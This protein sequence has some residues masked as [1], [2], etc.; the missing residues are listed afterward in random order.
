MLAKA[1]K[2]FDALPQRPGG[3][4]FEPKWDGFRGLVVNDG[5]TIEIAS[6]GSK[7][8]TRYF[9]ELVETFAEQVPPGCILDGELI[10]RR[11]RPGAERL[12]WP[13]LAQRIHPAQSRIRMLAEQTPAS[14][15]A[16]DMLAV[17]G[18]SLQDEP[19]EH[20]RAQLERVAEPFRAPVHLSRVTKDS[21]VAMRWFTDFEGAGLDGVIAKPAAEVYQPGKRAIFKLKHARTAD[22]V[23]L[24]YRV[25]KSG[26][27]IGSLLLGLYT[28]DGELAM[29][30]GA[31]SFTAKRRM[32]L[33][34][35]LRPL[36]VRDEND[37]PVRCAGDQNRF[38][39]GKDTSFM[40]LRPEVVAEVAYDQMEGH[41]FRHTVQLK[42]FRP[43]RDPRSCTYEQLR[44]PAAHD[45]DAVL[46][47][48]SG[49]GNG[50]AV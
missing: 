8:L 50:T 28:D 45:L 30:G 41:R 23:L 18:R 29:V 24:G 48:T 11:G 9:P 1:V 22:V 4:L 38:S 32:E 3:Y 42:R 6:R 16:F 2:S 46:T 25:H 33:L 43:D 7:P 15:V 5:A 34:E 39:S 37:E 31:A 21:A 19:F 13:T 14:F 44:M 12:D 36:V 47:G 27:G 26:Q 20:R 49:S 40:R 35:Q 17:A 10:L